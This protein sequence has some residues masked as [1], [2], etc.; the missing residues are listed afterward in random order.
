MRKHLSSI[1]IVVFVIAGL[2]LILYPVISN[3]KNSSKANV[4]I[5]EYDDEVKAQTE[6][7]WKQELQSAHDYNTRLYEG[8]ILPD[9]AGHVEGYENELNISGT[10]IMGYVN[11]DKIGVKLPIYHGTDNGVLQ[12]GAGHV[13]FSSLPVGGPSTHC[14]ISGHRGLPSATLFTDLP[15]L[16]IG[17]EF[18]ITVL[19]QVLTYRVDNIETVLPD[20]IG[21][22]LIV[23]GKDYCTLVT[24]TPYGIN[25]HRLLV[26][27]ERVQD[28]EETAGVLI[29]NQGIQIDP[30]VVA[31]FMAIPILLAVILFIYIWGR[32]GTTGKRSEKRNEK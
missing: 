26:R 7:E 15:E 9:N 6:A 22:L 8:S 31:V 11:I 19:D 10:G 14:V 13:G 2:G 17:D 24:C 28:K 12:V 25:S 21:D 4:L 18:T 3:L 20:E 23:E 30:P 29:T 27:G 5:V 32:T 1:L 16:E